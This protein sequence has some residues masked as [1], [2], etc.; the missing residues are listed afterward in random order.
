MTGQVGKE[1]GSNIMSQRFHMFATHLDSQE[2]NVA[3]VLVKP[4]DLV[5]KQPLLVEC[6]FLHVE[7]R[8]RFG[9]PKYSIIK[10]PLD[11]FL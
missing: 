5:I 8:R 6:G 1:M 10:C 9:L 3:K 7:R 4:S 2:S 11:T